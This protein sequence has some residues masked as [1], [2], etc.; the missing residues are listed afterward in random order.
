M[1][2]RTHARTHARRHACRQAGRQAGRHERNATHAR[3]SLPLRLALVHFLFLS[4][5]RSRSLSLSV[6]VFFFLSLSHT[7]YHPN[8][9]PRPVLTRH[10]R[11]H[12]HGTCSFEREDRV[13]PA[14]LCV[15]ECVRVLRACPCLCVSMCVCAR[16]LR[17]EE[18][19]SGKSFDCGGCLCFHRTKTVT[20]I[21]TNTKAM[22][23]YSKR[24]ACP[25]AKYNSHT[26]THM[27][28]T[29][30]QAEIHVQMHSYECMFRTSVCAG[31]CCKG[32]RRESKQRQ[33]NRKGQK[34]RKTATHAST[35]T[36]KDTG[37]DEQLQPAAG[38]ATT[39]DLHAR[40]HT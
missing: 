7:L 29:M 27:I 13:H 37:Q 15:G 14:S 16:K 4:R 34:Q 19:R 21:Y 40:T 24:H 30:V 17:R 5:S 9:N 20:G 31:A 22:Q 26:Y 39:L 35:A 3:A 8:P 6:S 1:R 18:E 38:I 23:V 10:P 11:S 25:H 28:Y 36:D 33:M 32:R 12:Q 2:A